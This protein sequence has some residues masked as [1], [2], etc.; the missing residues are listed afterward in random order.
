MISAVLLALGVAGAHY[1]YYLWP[2]PMGRS[3][4]AYIGTHALVVLTLMLLL[5]QAR[6]ARRLSFVA[7]TACWLG[8]IESTQAVVCSVYAWGSIPKSDLCIEAFGPW[9]YV[10]A[11]S[12]IGATV[13]TRG[14]KS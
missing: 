7:V 8:A 12:V 10:I 4:A 11:A 6:R 14:R 9:P 1:A 2:D 13:L 5:P 3:W